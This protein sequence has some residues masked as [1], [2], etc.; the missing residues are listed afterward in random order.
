[1]KRRIP[2]PLIIQTIFGPEVATKK[3]NCCEEEK[4]VHE[5][6]CVS[7]S[8]LNKFKRMGEQVREQCISC[9]SKYQ[10]RVWLP[11]YLKTGKII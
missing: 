1:M 10:G 5:F 3:C 2:D 6:Y 8:K 7:E 11:I 4:Y 9:W